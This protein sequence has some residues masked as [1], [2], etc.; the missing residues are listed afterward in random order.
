VTTANGATRTWSGTSAN[1]YEDGF[2]GFVT[3]KAPAITGND[4]GQGHFDPGLPW[5]KWQVCA[6]DGL[7]RNFLV[8]D[9]TKP[10]GS[11]TYQVLDLNGTG[12]E[13]KVCTASGW[14]V[15]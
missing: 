10:D 5:G 4:W 6:D 14:P 2:A 9:N 15:A 1:N 13:A 3:R 11:A 7:R 8:I 12:S